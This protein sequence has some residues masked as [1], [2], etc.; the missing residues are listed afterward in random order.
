MTNGRSRMVAAAALICCTATSMAEAQTYFMRHKLGNMK[1]R[2]TGPVMD[3]VSVPSPTPAVTWTWKE[4]PWGSWS[5]DCSRTA[6]RT[7]SVVCTGSDGSTGPDVS[8]P[9]VRP[10]SMEV[11]E[12]MTGCVVDTHAY[13]WDSGGWS[14]WSSTC[15]AT[16]VRTRPVTCVRDDGMLAGDAACDTGS[17]PPSHEAKEDYSGCSNRIQY[18]DADMVKGQYC[19]GQVAVRQNVWCVNRWGTPQDMSV[20]NAEGIPT[21]AQTISLPCTRRDTVTGNAFWSSGIPAGYD[22]RTAAYPGRLSESEAT[23]KALAQCAASDFLS[24]PQNHGFCYFV[25]Y[26]WV[27]RANVTIVE[28]G[29]RNSARQG[30][31]GTYDMT[32]SQRTVV[33]RF[34]TVTHEFL[35]DD[36]A[37]D[38]FQRRLIQ[39][40]NNFAVSDSND[41]VAAVRCVR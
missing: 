24:D 23:S 33:N 7:R 21:P 13:D 15:S 30:S 25:S 2:S 40:G 31:A 14:S 19:Q 26:T 39:C 27:P 17:K 1:E 41:Y 4:G 10:A 12:I 9:G 11:E 38:R 22:Y 28:A 37:M 32:G 16:A 35:V 20:C 8:C 29:P 18:N 3:P 6:V 36:S 34:N 5:S